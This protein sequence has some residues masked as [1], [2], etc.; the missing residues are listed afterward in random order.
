MGKAS[1]EALTKIASYCP[2]LKE[3][4]ITGHT[5][6]RK[7]TMHGV[8]KMVQHCPITTLHILSL[9]GSGNGVEHVQKILQC[10]SA[11]ACQ[12]SEESTSKPILE[13]TVGV[14]LCSDS[15]VSFRQ[16]ELQMKEVDQTFIDDW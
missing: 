10:M 15:S 11:S 13:L 3:L 16:Q 1:D 5:D 6:A 7:L 2:K 9:Q 8:V 4:K 12:S 14:R